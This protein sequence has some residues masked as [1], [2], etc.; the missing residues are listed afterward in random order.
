MQASYIGYFRV[1][2][3]GWI[4][5]PL[6]VGGGTFFTWSL[7]QDARYAQMV[8]DAPNDS[9]GWIIEAVPRPWLIA[10]SVAVT[11]L[12]ALYFVWLVLAALQRR[13]SFRI[14]A[15]GIRSYG[16]FT[17]RESHLAWPQIRSLW[18]YKSRVSVKGKDMVGRTRRVSFSVLGHSYK[19]VK[20]VIAIFRPDLV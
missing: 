17:G 9:H 8:R 16:I 2:I 7:T 18:K 15:G 1:P 14:D 20:A 3:V 13:L 12:F 5:F 4:G 11:I 10:L 6:L 19:Q